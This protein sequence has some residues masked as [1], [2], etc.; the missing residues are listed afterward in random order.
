MERSGSL[1]Q[2]YEAFHNN[3]SLFSPGGVVL[4]KFLYWKVPPPLEFQPL[5]LL[6]TIFHEKGTRF[7]YLLLKNGT[8]FTYL[9]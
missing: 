3:G 7:V 5:I 2:Q 8:L 9:V 1:D 6:Y 4:N